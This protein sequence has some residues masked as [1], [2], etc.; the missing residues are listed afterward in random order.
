MERNYIRRY[1]R[2]RLRRTS[3]DAGSIPATSTSLPLRRFAAQGKAGP[4][5]KRSAGQTAPRGLGEVGP[6]PRIGS[7]PPV[8]DCRQSRASEIADDYRE[9]YNRR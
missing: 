7:R 8:H 9:T 2:R 1:T 4:S 6:V 3:S 5:T